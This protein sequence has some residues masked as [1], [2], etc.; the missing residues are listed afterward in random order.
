[1]GLN[2]LLAVSFVLLGSMLCI[3]SHEEK[4]TIQSYANVVADEL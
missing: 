3:Y 1:M 4:Q 2:Q